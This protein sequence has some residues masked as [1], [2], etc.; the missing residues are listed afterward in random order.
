MTNQWH[1]TV[2]LDELRRQ[3][4]VACDGTRD[5]SEVSAEVAR[6][7]RHTVPLTSRDQL[8]RQIATQLPDLLES[9]ARLGL[10]L[11]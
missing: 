1:T 6:S 3:T 7:L 4:L 8:E 5:Y 11:K 10:L 9:L 2:E